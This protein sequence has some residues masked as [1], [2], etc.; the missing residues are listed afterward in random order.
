MSILF[1]LEDCFDEVAA[2]CAAVPVAVRWQALDVGDLFPA[3]FTFSHFF[4]LK[5]VQVHPLLS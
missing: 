5:H 3:V 2:S 1:L 4:S